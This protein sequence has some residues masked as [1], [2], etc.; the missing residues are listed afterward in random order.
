MV[1]AK[2]LQLPIVA[3]ARGKQ[4]DKSLELA[5]LRTMSAGTQFV[6]AED[7]KTLNCPLVFR[8]K[9]DNIAGTQIA[10]LCAYPCAR[11]ILDWQKPNPAFQI[12]RKHFYAGKPF[13]G[14]KWFP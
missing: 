4:E 12:V 7:F 8:S 14:F 6:K 11:Y 3:E 13:G 9:R 5:F 10:D 1:S 2:E